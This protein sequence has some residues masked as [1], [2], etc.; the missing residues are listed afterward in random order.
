MQ[1]ALTTD[2]EGLGLGP[3]CHWLTAAYDMT[4]RMVQPT[5]STQQA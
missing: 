1:N 4:V 3:C 5:F 2:P